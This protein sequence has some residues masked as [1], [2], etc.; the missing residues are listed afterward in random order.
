MNTELKNLIGKKVTRIFISLDDLRFETD[1]GNFT[2]HVDGDCC[3]NSFFYDF[4]GVKNLLKNGK[5]I[6]I[7]TVE[8]LPSDVAAFNANGSDETK[9]YGYQITTESKD[10]GD[11][12]SVF[13][14]R[15]IS[16][17]YYGGGIQLTGN[18]EGLP[19]IFDDVKEVK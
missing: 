5:I 3:S 15:N 10:Y 7:K 19:E 18:K 8:L 6:E 13:S 2:Y 12:T 9:V 11:V 14:F 4:Y 16:N 17:G 1:G